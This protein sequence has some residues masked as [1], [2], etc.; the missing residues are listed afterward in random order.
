MTG[1]SDPGDETDALPDID[2]IQPARCKRC[3]ATELALC[4]WDA[5]H[6]D[7]PWERRPKDCKAQ[8]DPATAVIPY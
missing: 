2:A 6:T 1:Y 3:G 8:Y 4:G 5:D 7:I